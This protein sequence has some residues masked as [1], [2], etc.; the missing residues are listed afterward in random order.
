MKSRTIPG[1]SRI[2]GVCC[3]LF[4]GLFVLYHVQQ[5]D[6]LRL[7]VSRC[8]QHELTMR[9]KLDGEMEKV[10]RL[11]KRLE[12]NRVSEEKLQQK[13]RDLRD[14]ALKDSNM[15]FAS[16]QQHYKLLQ[17]E[18][19]DVK[20]EYANLQRSQAISKKANAAA[21]VEWKVGGTNFPIPLANLF[22][23]FSRNTQPWRE[24]SSTW[25]VQ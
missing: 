17:S 4:F 6:D 1:K 5:V 9:S 18:H 24:D 7:A 11:E 22:T 2:L 19:E 3:L 20:V 13:F 21:I 14:K 10:E 15:R 8:D 25:N 12:V 16:L 23:T